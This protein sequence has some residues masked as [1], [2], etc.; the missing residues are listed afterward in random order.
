MPPK[1]TLQV[2]I[3]Q[4][5]QIAREVS[6]L[7]DSQAAAVEKAPESSISTAERPKG[8]TPVNSPLVSHPSASCGRNYGYDSKD[9]IRPSILGTYKIWASGDGPG[10]AITPA[11]KTQPINQYEYQ[12]WKLYTEFEESPIDALDPETLPRPPR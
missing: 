8:F 3:S 9:K 1:T 11:K 4:A 2:S 5:V 6:G 10:D 7:V 12:S